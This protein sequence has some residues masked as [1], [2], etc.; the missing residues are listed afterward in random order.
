MLID[1]EERHQATSP[2]HSYIVEA[3]AGSGKT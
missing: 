2:H 3:P 1:S